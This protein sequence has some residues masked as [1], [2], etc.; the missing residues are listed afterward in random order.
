[1]QRRNVLRQMSLLGAGA[2][3]AP[4]MSLAKGLARRGNN[5]KLSL[6]AYSFHSL[7]ST[8]KMSLDDLFHFCA[9]EGLPAVDLTAYYIEGYPEVPDDSVLYGIKRKAHS[10][11]LAISGTGIRNDFTYA[12]RDKHNEQIIFCK[13]WIEAAA[14]LGAPVLRV[15]AGTQSVEPSFRERLTAWIAVNFMACADTGA[16]NGVIVALQN[17]DDFIQ[18]ADEVNMYLEVVDSPWFGLVL[19]I[20]SY[21][22][23]DTYEG[24]Q[25]NIRHAVNWQLKEN[26]NQ[27]GKQV[28]VD[29][30]RLFDIIGG[31]S[32]QGYLPIETLGPGDPYQKVRT[33][34]A[35]VRKHVPEK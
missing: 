19:D 8:G 25:K 28:P 7:L 20:G 16:A 21:P 6:N 35:E 15:F 33:F 32:Y 24:I 26:V 12:D 22:Q 4:G 14:K 2:M 27:D 5:L 13:K 1:M 29:L 23:E 3:L 10:Y 30:S 31:S 34:L 9:E 17:H 11:G 18:T